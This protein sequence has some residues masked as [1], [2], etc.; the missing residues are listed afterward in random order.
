MFRWIE[1]LTSASKHQETPKKMPAHSPTDILSDPP[2]PAADE[3]L[4][5]IYVHVP[6]CLTKCPYCSFFSQPY[7]EDLACRYLAALKSQIMAMGSHPWTKGRNFGSL[8]IG[9]GT[10]TVYRA[11]ELGGLVE[12]CLRNFSFVDLPEI[13]VETNPNTVN[14]EKLRALGSVGVNRLSIGV[15]SFSDQDLTLLGRSHTASEAGQA[16][17]LARRAGF[18]NINIDLMFGL[19]GQKR[20]DWTKTLKRALEFFPEHLS[21]YELTIEEE[22]PFFSRRK[23]G[24]LSVPGEETL[25]AMANTTGAILAAGNYIH[26]EISNFARPGFSCGHNVMYWGNGSYLGLGA[27]AVSC[28]SGFRVKNI[29]D[30]KRFIEEVGKGRPAFSEGECLM[31]EARFRESVVMGLRMLKGVSIERVTRRFGILPKDYYGAILPRLMAQG[32]IEINDGNLRLSR[33][34][35]PL[36][37]QILSQLV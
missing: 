23:Q 10:P 21:V 14:L 13:S 18:A 2:G 5:G 7:D 25:L 22:T 20:R 37:N 17:D 36:A 31:R 6:F 28:F 29:A 16:I 8:Y 35:L 15:Q 11:K 4:P 26:Y 24:E 33:K 12:T 30:G 3:G 1:E 32:Y 27:G 9:G 19:P 34:G